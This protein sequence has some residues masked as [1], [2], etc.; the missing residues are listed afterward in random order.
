MVKL[1]VGVGVIEKVKVS[2]IELVGVA[3]FVGVRVVV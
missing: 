3:V 2:V 1:E